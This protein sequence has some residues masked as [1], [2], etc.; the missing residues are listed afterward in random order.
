MLIVCATRYRSPF[1]F[2]AFGNNP[3]N[4]PKKNTITE[5]RSSLII[6][7]LIYQE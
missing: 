5:C 4:F 3:L 6:L 2:C 1:L 7:F